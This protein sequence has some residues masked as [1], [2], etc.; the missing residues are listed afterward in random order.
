[1]GATANFRKL[2]F[3]DNGTQTNNVTINIQTTKSIDDPALAEQLY[4][5]LVDKIKIAANN[6]TGIAPIQPGAGGMYG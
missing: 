3:R 5:N 1:V 2:T 4:N 6:D